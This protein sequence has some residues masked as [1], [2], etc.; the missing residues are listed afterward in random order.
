[1]ESAIEQ[2]TM[3]QLATM[4]G[5]ILIKVITKVSTFIYIGVQCTFVLSRMIIIIIFEM[6]YVNSSGV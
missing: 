6:K 4:L 5:I 1:M 3:R 2:R